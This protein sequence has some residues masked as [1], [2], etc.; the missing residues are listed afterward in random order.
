MAEAKRGGSTRRP[1]HS[2]VRKQQAEQTRE[3][4]LA[5]AREKFADYLEHEVGNL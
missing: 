5:A 3:R 1:Y 4:I 2:P